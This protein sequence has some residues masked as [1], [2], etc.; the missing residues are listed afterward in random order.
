MYI[1][2]SKVGCPQCDTAKNFAKMRGV[3]HTVKMLDVDYKLNDLLD[4]AQMPVRQMPF[5]MKTVDNTMIPV[6]GLQQFMS[7]VNNG[8]N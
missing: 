3:D 2:F 6:G 4:I 5:I 1:I 7:E 8:N